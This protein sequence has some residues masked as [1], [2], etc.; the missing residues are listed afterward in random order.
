MK[1]A[2]R[3]NLGPNVEIIVIP[4]PSYQRP[5]MNGDGQPKRDEQ[6][7]ILMEEIPGDIVFKCQ[8]VLDYSE[9]LALCP[10][11]QPGKIMKRG[12]TKAQDDFTDPK[13]H[14]AINRWSGQRTDWMILK[15]LEATPDFQWETIDM[16]KPETWGNYKQEFE[17]AG[18]TTIEVGRIIRDGVAAA[19]GLDE[20]KFQEA[21]K[22][23]LLTQG[24]GIPE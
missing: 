17:K 20:S 6:G 18:F 21:K 1:F 15:S 9:F 5:I 4:R 11:P 10:E 19:N 14:D 3:N 12:E 2:N 8:A 13:Y 22:R 23:F 24:A 16:Q 7:N